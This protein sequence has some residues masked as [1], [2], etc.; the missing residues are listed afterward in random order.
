VSGITVVLRG[1]LGLLVFAI[2]A[3]P[4]LAGESK[5]ILTLGSDITEIVYV[6][7]AGEWLAG[8]DA[9]STYPDAA[10]ALPDV[11]YFRQLG[12]EGV[13]SLRPDLILASA[14]A[15]P[16]QVL[17]QIGA[18]GVRI[19]TMAEGYSPELL[20]AKV[21]AV[22]LALQLPEKGVA[23][24]TAR[25]RAEIADART[26]V[27]AMR[28]RPKVLFLI[29]GGAPMAAG[30]NTAADAMI[31][32][33]GG[34]NVFSAHSGYKP[35]SLEAAAAA[36]PDAI[37]MMDQT[38]TAMG[39]VSGAAKHPALMLTPAAKTGRIIARNGSALLSF[40]PRLPAAM[41]DFARAIRGETPRAAAV[42]SEA[43]P[44]GIAAL[45]KAQQRK[46][47]PYSPKRVRG[48]MEHAVKVCPP[49]AIDDDAG[50]LG[51]SRG[52]RVINLECEGQG[53]RPTAPRRIAMCKALP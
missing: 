21:E 43:A 48:F 31:A 5:R 41:V 1:A 53:R 46:M 30:R 13:L 51:C 50:R 14:Q 36:A 34:E 40:G 49:K 28:G 45:R 33:A 29:G 22:G 44:A 6:L 2:L 27:A 18:A 9:T 17:K 32:L 20:L 42:L 24:V 26:A 3:A 25:L 12:A 8:R 37:A 11:C 7:G 23:E 19:V 15:G 47:T 16:P 4:A 38:L 35:I 10:K 52:W 39:G